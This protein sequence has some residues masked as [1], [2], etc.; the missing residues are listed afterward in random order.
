MSLFDKIANLISEKP[1]REA[2]DGQEQ[3]A[4][5]M[6][7]EN[8]GVQ[9]E[10]IADNTPQQQ[11]TQAQEQ[12]V[13]K[14]KQSAPTLETREEML[15][16]VC[17]LSCKLFDNVELNVGNQLVI[18]LDTDQ[19]TFQ[20]YDTEPYRQRIL[21][22]LMNECDLRLD[23]VTFRIGVPAEELRCTPVGK[24]GKV[25]LQMLEEKSAPVVVSRKAVISIFGNAGSLLKEEYIL[26]SDEMKEKRISAYNIGAG[27]FPQVPTGYRQNH[28]A[29]DDNPTGP[30][31]EKNKF[32]S[33]MHAHIG[34]SDNFGFYLQVE[35]DGTR[36]MGKRT[37]IFRGEEKI[38]M[39]NPQAKEPLQDG[40][41]IELG[42]AVVLR[43]TQVNS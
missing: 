13:E 17:D 14:E 32:V 30:M 38:E 8:E 39:D 28:I 2:S 35:R 10:I 24:S 16:Y 43:Y 21:A 23:T 20:A 40:D 4:S 18:W 19:L 3:Q 6:N 22:A 37:R 11:E 12:G 33:R 36:L 5:P 1:K 41:L 9:D 29:I 27:E 34:Y 7:A 25:F 15:R 31:I 42:K 26:S